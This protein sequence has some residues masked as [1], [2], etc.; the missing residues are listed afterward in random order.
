[1]IYDFKTFEMAD[2][3]NRK[4]G[5]FWGNMGA[6]V[7][8]LAR[9]SGKFLISMRSK[10]VNEPRTYGVIGGKV[11]NENALNLE[12]EALRELKEETGFDG[13]I[14]MQPL[15]V[16]KVPTFEYHTF[17]GIVDTEFKPVPEPRH[18]WENEFLKL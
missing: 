8:V 2:Y 3:M 10:W 9:D 13:Q 5:K 17:L 11:D 18:A 1:M 15:S 16:Y 7:L 4:G 12:S 6:G 14:N